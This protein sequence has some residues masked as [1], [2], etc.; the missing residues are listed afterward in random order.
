M[1]SNNGN[2]DDGTESEAPLIN[3]K[4]SKN[5]D[6]IYAPIFDRDLLLDPR[7]RP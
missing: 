7:L 2:V 1:E 6:R 3:G 4:I 5:F